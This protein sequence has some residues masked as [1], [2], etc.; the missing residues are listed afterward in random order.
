[1]KG[2][3]VFVAHMEEAQEDKVTSVEDCSIL[4]EF[5]DVFKEISGLPL[6]RYID[7]SIN[8]IPGAIPVSKTPYRMST[9]KLKELHM[10][11][12]KLLKK[13]YIHPSVSP[14]GGL[15]LFMKK[16]DDTLKLCIDF[17]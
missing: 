3:Q 13:G 7:F 1:M 9:P 11:L 14:R 12:E 2:C 8:M 10:Q 6:K 16:K 4:K 15:V 17:R 5:E